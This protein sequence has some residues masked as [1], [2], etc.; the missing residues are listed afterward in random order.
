MRQT[1]LCQTNSGDVVHLNILSSSV[2]TITAMCISRLSQTVFFESKVSRIYD[3]LLVVETT[4]SPRS[5]AAGERP[6]SR[7]LDA[8][9]NLDFAASAMA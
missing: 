6:G 9:S 3:A 2:I 4:T 1:E 8:P 7:K 5:N